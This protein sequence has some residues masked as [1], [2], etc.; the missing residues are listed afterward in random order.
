[1]H[2]ESK[3]S[4]IEI[5]RKKRFLWEPEKANFKSFKFH[6]MKTYA[7]R[8]Y[9]CFLNSFEIVFGVIAGTESRYCACTKLWISDRM[10]IL[11][12]SAYGFGNARVSSGKLCARVAKIWLFGPHRA[13]SLIQPKF[14]ASFISTSSR[15][16][17]A[18]SVLELKKFRL[19]PWRI[20]RYPRLSVVAAEK[21]PLNVPNHRFETWSLR[22][23]DSWLNISVD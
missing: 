11:E 1:M 4:V 12:P 18:A 9:L 5:T 20:F 3:I 17:C 15:K 21:I 10:S 16:P 19:R 2:R 7:W 14:F 22:M 23:L 8:F 6:K 13:C